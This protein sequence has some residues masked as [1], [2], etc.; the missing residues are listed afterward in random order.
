M[1]NI[2]AHPKSPLGIMYATFPK[3][4]GKLKED[5]TKMIERFEEISLQRSSE[6]DPECDVTNPANEHYNDPNGYYDSPVKPCEW[7]IIT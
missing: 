1:K 5:F 2:K 7:R 4:K 3:L 6:T